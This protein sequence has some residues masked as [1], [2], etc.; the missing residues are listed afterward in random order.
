MFGRVSTVS[1]GAYANEFTGVQL[2]KNGTFSYTDNNVQQLS[3]WYENDNGTLVFPEYSMP[4]GIPEWVNAYNPSTHGSDGYGFL[5]SRSLIGD[6]TNS[7]GPFS[8]H[9]ALYIYSVLKTYAVDGYTATANNYW[10][11]QTEPPNYQQDPTYLFRPQYKSVGYS[12][13]WENEGG[14]YSSYVMGGGG[15]MRIV[16]DVDDLSKYYIVGDHPQNTMFAWRGGGDGG[17]NFAVGVG[18]IK[19]PYTYYGVTLSEVGDSNSHTYEYGEGLTFT[20]T[21]TY[22]SISVSCT[23]GSVSCTVPMYGTK[24][25]W[26]GYNWLTGEAGED[27]SYDPTYPSSLSV[28]GIN[29]WPYKTANGQPVYDTSTGAVLN[30]PLS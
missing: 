19:F 15:E 17:G 18:L 23:F 10:G 25:S 21:V 12:A 20:E 14:F 16:A 29:F 1:L 3:G 7:F 27:Q 6:G 13:F 8:L 2:G 22:I 5:T 24:V 26:Q 30:S 28:S 9:D 4:S 11:D